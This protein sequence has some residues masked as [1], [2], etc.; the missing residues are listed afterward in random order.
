[1]KKEIVG[2]LLAATLML[3]L[4]GCATC[5]DSGA[6][7]YKAVPCYSQDVGKTINDMSQQGWHF[8]S[9][10]AGAGDAT[11]WPSALL[12]FKKHK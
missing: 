5:K 1:M 3:G 9:L 8:V 2:L 7:E 4:T 12:L 10:S 6:W 11:H